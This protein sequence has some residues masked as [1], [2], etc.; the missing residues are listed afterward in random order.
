MDISK[1]LNPIRNKRPRFDESAVEVD[2]L[3]LP[4][5]L[6]A[7]IMQ[8]IY[9]RI[10]SRFRLV[11]KSWYTAYEL[12][13]RNLIFDNLVHVNRPKVTRKQTLDAFRKYGHR[14]RFLD[15]DTNF[16]RYMLEYEPNFAELIPNVT[17]TYIGIRDGL[18]SE[19]WV[20]NVLAKLTKLNRISIAEYGY[21]ADENLAAELDK[22]IGNMPHF[23]QFAASDMDLD[24]AVLTGENMRLIGGKLTVLDVSIPNMAAGMVAPTLGVFKNVAILWLKLISSIEVLHK[25]TEVVTNPKSF[26]LL[27]ELSVMTQVDITRTA[28]IIDEQTGERITGYGLFKK[29]C[30]IRRPRFDLSVGFGLGACSTTDAALIET[31]RNFIINL[32]KNH[33]D[34]LVGLEITHFT[35]VGDYDPITTFLYESVPRFERLA[36]M[37]FYASPTASTSPKLIAALNNSFLL[38]YLA[39]VDVI[40]DGGQA[41]EWNSGSNPL[42]TSRGVMVS[43]TLEDND[44]KLRAENESNNGILASRFLPDD[45]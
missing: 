38:P 8:F 9:F 19:L 31:E 26:P 14:L 4:T 21:D 28:P 22:A 17:S 43:T 11:S 39:F 44:D 3:W 18:P 16:L 5:E 2:K 32:A 10:R 41:P 40:V 29:I 36:F 37:R 27:S 23:R 42:D 7:Y 35:P 20:G 6:I 33:N 15:V 30:S 45:V 24:I 34:V 1:L 12:Y 13:H 25:V